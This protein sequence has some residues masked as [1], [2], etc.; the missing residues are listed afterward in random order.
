MIRVVFEGLEY[1]VPQDVEALVVC[2][3]RTFHA[4]HT[5]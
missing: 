2:T 1:L 3:R 4:V 5:S